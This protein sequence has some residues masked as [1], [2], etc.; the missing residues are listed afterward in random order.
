MSKFFYEVP[1]DSKTGEKISRFW[2]KCIRC[3]QAAEKYAKKMGG[4]YYY[5]DPRYFAGGVVCIAFDE[6][7]RIDKQVWRVS[8]VDRQDGV[9][10]YEPDCR[11]RTGAVEVTS[12]DYKPQDTFCRYHDQERIFEREGKLFVPYVEFYRD[13][14]AGPK[15]YDGHAERQ[16]SRGLRKAIKAEVQRK[17]L[18]VMRTEALLH[19]LGADTGVAGAG[20]SEPSTPT[21]FAFRSR[22]FIGCD[23]DCSGNPDLKGIS[24]QMY[25]LNRSRCELESRRGGA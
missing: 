20:A 16:A 4:K 17:R 8:G 11:E 19:I 21:F 12:R 10:Y 6:G 9:T 2:E 3:E 15:R 14:P 25:N 7:Q 13:E 24:P 1:A 23:Y 18:P 5:S 22:Y